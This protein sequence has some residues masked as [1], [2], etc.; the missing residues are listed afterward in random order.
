M[1]RV[2][3]YGMN[4]LEKP[5]E[6]LILNENTYDDNYSES[7]NIYGSRYVSKLFFLYTF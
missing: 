1:I 3:C 2:Y 6:Y 7:S 5:L 4:F